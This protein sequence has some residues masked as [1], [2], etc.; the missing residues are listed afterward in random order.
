M[1]YFS[2]AS[3]ADIF[4][5]ECC[6]CLLFNKPCPIAMA[7]AEFNYMACGDIVALKIL[8]MLVKQDSNYKYLGCQMKPLIDQ[9]REK[10][11]PNQLKLFE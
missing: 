8:N 9:L 6:D 5:M 7:Q 4:E 2:N 1:A 10:A 11:D 3:E